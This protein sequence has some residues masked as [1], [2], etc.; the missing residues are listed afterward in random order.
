[1]STIFLT[2][3][4][5]SF[6]AL[7]SNCTHAEIA[8]I[9]GQ[10]YAKILFFWA[11]SCF[12]ISGFAASNTAFETLW[13]LLFLFLEQMAS[14]Q[15]SVKHYFASGRLSGKLLDSKGWI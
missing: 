9:V 11:P 14:W 6:S 2:R 3:L 8:A 4:F 5:P 12:D 13:V 15:E 10:I 1:M 7:S